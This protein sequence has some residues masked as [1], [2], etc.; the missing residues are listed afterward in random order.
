M[1]EERDIV[2]QLIDG[3]NDGVNAI[4]FE[5]DVLETNRPDDWG[6]VEITGQGDADW[7]DGNMTDQE[8]TADVWVCVGSHGS[9][10][11]REVQA[12]LKA[13]SRS[14]DMGWKLVNRAYLYDL[15]KV[16]W[17]WQVTMVGPLAD[18]EEPEEDPGEGE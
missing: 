16:L 13:F 3:L 14:H 7:G 4:Q 11:K 18:E 17:H 10:A 2:D 9:R 5:R 1:D 8:I 12:V 6:A 15:D